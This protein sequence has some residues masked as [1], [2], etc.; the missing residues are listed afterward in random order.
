MPSLPEDEARRRLADSRVA[1][2]ATVRANGR[3]HVVPIVFAVEGDTVYSIADPKPKEALDLLRHRNIRANPG[4]S[5][6]VDAYD[7]TW[8]RLWWVR[9]DGTATVLDA[10][11]ERNTTIRLLIAKYPQYETLSDPFGA[12]TVISVERVTSWTM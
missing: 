10:G 8:G 12:A 4:V 9:V 5:L 7:E 6:L 11:T 3:P 1:Y 2:L